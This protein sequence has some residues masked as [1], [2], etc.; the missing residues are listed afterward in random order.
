MEQDNYKLKPTKAVPVSSTELERIQRDFRFNSPVQKHKTAPMPTAGEVWKLHR[1]LPS[2]LVLLT[3]RT[4]S[5]MN[6]IKQKIRTRLL[7]ERIDS[8]FDERPYLYDVERFKREHPGHHIQLRNTYS[9]SWHPTLSLLAT[10]GDGNIAR[11]WNTNGE[12]ITKRALWHTSPGDTLCWSSSGDLFI[13]D[14][15]IFD[16]NTG[17]YLYRSTAPWTTSLRYS[18]FSYRNL[19][20]VT[21]LTEARPIFH[22]PTISAPGDPI[23][24]S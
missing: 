15:D 6:D 8:G 2:G 16:G 12:A 14:D 1:T 7:G 23:P 11:V 24:R 19:R 21:L 10:I 22:P 5:F 13:C 9:V 3:G 20:G 18:S 17:E 4:F